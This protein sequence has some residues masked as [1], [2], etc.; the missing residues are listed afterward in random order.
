MVYLFMY[1]TDDDIVL[2]ITEVQTGRRNLVYL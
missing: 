1:T 2:S